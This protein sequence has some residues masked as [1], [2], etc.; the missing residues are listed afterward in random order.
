MARQEYL[1]TDKA[2]ARK[3]SF[4]C[5]EEQQKAEKKELEKP[6]THT[7][8]PMSGKKLRLKD[9]IPCKL[10]LSSK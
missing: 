5:A 7:T 4:W 6:D 3:K 10:E 1:E 8:C 2:E 9:L